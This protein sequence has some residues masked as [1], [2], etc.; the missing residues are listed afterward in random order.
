MLDNV[1]AVLKLEA[2]QRRG[3]IARLVDTWPSGAVK[4]LVT[5]AALRLR[6]RLTDLFLEGDYMPMEVESAGNGRAVAFA[7]LTPDHA[8][9]VIAPHLSSGLLSEERPLPLGDVWRTSRVLLPTPLA[10]V[11]FTDAITGAVVKP[12]TTAS[13]SW[14]FVGQA[15][16]LLPVALLTAAR[17]AAA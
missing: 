17:S 13:D 7:R 8:V 1:D 4:L 14:I 15:F 10:H 3:A 11:T 9:V 16:D 12:V 6:A 5:A 2:D